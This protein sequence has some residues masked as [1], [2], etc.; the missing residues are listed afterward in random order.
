MS[1]WQDLSRSNDKDKSGC[2]LPAGFFRLRYFHGKQMRLADYVDEQTYHRGKMRF[3]NDKLHGAGILCGLTVAKL[4]DV[5]TDLRVG[6]GA[7]LDDCGREIVVGY[8]QC[9]DAGDWFRAQKKKPREDEQDHCQPDEDRRVRI[10]VVIRYSE[11]VGSPEPIPASPCT[12]PSDCGCRGGASCGCGSAPCSDPCGNAAEFGRATEEFELRLMFRDEAKRLTRHDLFP[13]MADIGTAVA[14]ASGGVSLLKALAHPIRGKCPSPDEGWLMLACFDLVFDTQDD[15]KIL[16][17]DNI[18]I[19]C[20]SQVLLSTEVIQH[21]LG[22]LYGEIDPDIGGPE[23]SNIEMRHVD[24]DTYQIMISL[25]APIQAASLDEE[26]S[27]TLR[28]LTTTGWSP[29]ANNV[30]VARYGD[31]MTDDT[32]IVGPAIY[33]N[34]DNSGGFLADG[35]KY[36]LYAPPESHPIVDADLR[37]LRPRHMILRFGIEPDADDGT[38]TMHRL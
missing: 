12:P 27:L 35:G 32:P 11:C 13:S 37:H 26:T 36:H 4:D 7:A 16:G 24:G 15:D 30:L 25:T 3:H 5:G 21:L 10:C 23:V 29:P 31:T 1:K 28:R 38:L 20:A 14:D 33:L 2:G 19:D 8:D 9:I 18:D 6:R 22:S 34:I 17:I